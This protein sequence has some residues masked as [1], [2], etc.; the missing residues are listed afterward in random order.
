MDK[1]TKWLIWQKWLKGQN[2]PFDKNK[3]FDKNDSFEAIANLKQKRLFWKSAYL[4]SEYIE[5]IT[6]SANLAHMTKKTNLTQKTYIT[7]KY[8]V[9]KMAYFT[10]WMDI[11][12]SY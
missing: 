3:W 11:Q 8:L 10:K 6:K 5:K 4:Q 1:T 7:K 9:L 2:K 12:N